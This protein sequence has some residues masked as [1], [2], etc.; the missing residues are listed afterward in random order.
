[1][2]VSRL[3]ARTS[4]AARR[5]AFT[6]MEVM[7]VVAI[8]VILASVA[9]VAVFGY[10]DTANEKAARLKIAN[11]ESAVTSYKL[12]HGSFP[13]SLQELTVAE[14][15]KHALLEADTI[16][17]PWQKPFQYDPGQLSQSGKPKIWTTTEG[18]TPISNW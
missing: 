9:S 6:L 16:L 2:I 12:D 11:I 5:V 14:G 17:D 4:R 18:G 3:P 13:T 10:L 7:V 8:L 15:G 1:M